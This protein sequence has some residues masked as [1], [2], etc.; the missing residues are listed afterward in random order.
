MVF[1]RDGY[2]Q[3]FSCGVTG[4]AVDL[5]LGDSVDLGLRVHALEF[6]V[7]VAVKEFRLSYRSGNVI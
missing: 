7:W 2:G 6:K 5:D 4:V 3:A 1:G